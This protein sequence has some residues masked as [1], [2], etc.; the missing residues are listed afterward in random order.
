MKFDIVIGNP[1]YNRGIDIDFVALGY[2]LSSMFCSMITP[3]KW[4]TAEVDQRVTSNMAYCEFQ[5]RLVPYIREL[6]FFP[7]CKDIFDIFQV[8][9]IVY[10]VMDKH[11]HDTAVVHN[12]CRSLEILNSTATRSIVH[13]ESLLNAGQEIYEYVF[14]RCGKHFELPNIHYGDK[15]T[16]WLVDQC[17]GGCFSTVV[18]NKQTLFIGRCTIVSSNGNYEPVSTEIKAFSSNSIDEC[19]SFKSWLQ[20][21]FTQFFV[22]MNQNKVKGNFNPEGLRFVPAPPNGLFDHIYTDEELYKHFG[23]TDEHIAIIESVVKSRD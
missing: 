11:R 19:F 8:D 4:Q 7:C 17:P 14:S 21:K 13:R 1:P 2:S 10:F 18:K 22:A 16:V 15:Y 23:L 6:C 3:A 5:T 9:G 12:K 20:S